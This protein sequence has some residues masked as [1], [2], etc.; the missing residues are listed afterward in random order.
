MILY[1]SSVADFF[2]FN[3]LYT[4]LQLRL[5]NFFTLIRTDVNNFPHRVIS[6]TISISHIFCSFH[7]LQTDKIIVFEE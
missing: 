6:E 4:N 5:H 1:R 2:H 3:T 7:L